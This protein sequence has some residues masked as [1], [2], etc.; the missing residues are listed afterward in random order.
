M[1]FIEGKYDRIIK[2]FK[3]KKI[4]IKFWNGNVISRRKRDDTKFLTIEEVLLCFKQWIMAS[5]KFL[6]FPLGKHER[7]SVLL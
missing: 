2:C 5:I 6:L 1:Y 3:Y 4:W 7:V